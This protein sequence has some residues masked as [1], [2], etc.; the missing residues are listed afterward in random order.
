MGALK[1]LAAIATLVAATPAH[2]DPVAALRPYVE[3]AASRCGVPVPWIERVMRIESG[4][5]TMLAG[6]PI[7]SGAGAMGLMQLMPTTWAAMRVALGL[8]D[9]PHDPHDNIVAGACYLRLMIDRFGVPGAFAAYNAGPGRYAD[10]LAGRRGLPG[11]T[12]RYVAAIG[13]TAPPPTPAP[14]PAIM[15]VTVSLFAV[16]GAPGRPAAAAAK[17]LFFIRY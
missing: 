8:G 15:P 5:R 14:Q 11:E 17:G 6:R 12:V 10:Y 2:A 4:G 7:V 9:N 3:G 13:G 16:G 1:P